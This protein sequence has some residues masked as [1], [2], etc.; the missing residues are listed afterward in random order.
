MSKPANSETCKFYVSPEQPECGVKAD[1]L[2]RTR[3][4]DKTTATVP[5]CKKH[6]AEHDRAFAERRAARR[7]EGTDYL[8]KGGVTRL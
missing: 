1:A 8:V 4:T 7:D 2:V 5:L 3:L 6:K